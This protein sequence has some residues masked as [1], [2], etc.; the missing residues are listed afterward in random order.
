MRIRIFCRAGRAKRSSA[1]RGRGR[2]LDLLQL[3]EPGEL[4]DPNL[5]LACFGY[6]PLP[7]AVS[8]SKG[9]PEA[10]VVDKIDQF[11]AELGDPATGASEQLL[12]LKF[13]L[14]VIGDLHQ[15]STGDLTGEAAFAQIEFAT[16]SPLEGGVWC[17]LVSEFLE[18]IKR[19]PNH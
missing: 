12:A 4:A 13:L 3:F 5:A 7:P 8:A 17:E 14:H 11:A 2:V 6:P 18:S 16:D 19:G 10:C 15:P 1:T 9:P